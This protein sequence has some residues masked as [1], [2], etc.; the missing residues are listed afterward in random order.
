TDDADGRAA[1]GVRNNGQPAPV[2]VTSGQPSVLIV[3][4]VRIGYRRGERVPEDRLSLFETHAVVDKI[5]NGLCDVPFK[6]H[7]PRPLP[8]SPPVPYIP[9]PEYPPPG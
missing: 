7:A 2:G 1:V 9:G 8:P 3:R 5:R 4:M 6:F